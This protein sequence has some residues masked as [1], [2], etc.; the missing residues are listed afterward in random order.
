MVWEYR[1]FVRQ[2]DDD[3]GAA[4][5]LL[6]AALHATTRCSTGGASTPPLTPD[7]PAE[8]RTD[9]Y[10]PTDDDDTGVKQRGGG[11]AGEALE[12]KWVTKRDAGGAEKLLK[13]CLVRAPGGA[14]GGWRAD[15]GAQALPADIASKVD[16]ALARPPLVVTKKR[17]R[18]VSTD[19]AMCYEV[20]ELTAR[21]AG[22]EAQRWLSVCV[23]G[24][25][26]QAVAEAGPRLAA[27]LRDEAP[28]LPRKAQRVG[29]Y[30][31]LVRALTAAAAA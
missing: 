11:G 25:T 29:G 17:W 19:R 4:A 27:T 1:F 24:S 7:A 2:P 30:A 22:G 13:L 21:G 15:G 14:C 23:E 28:Q 16:A 12:L 20:T 8:Q 9:S 31:A 18:A 3:A 5:V 6:C 26:R 10:F